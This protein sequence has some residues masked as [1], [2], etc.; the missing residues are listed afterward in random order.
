MKSPAHCDET[1][2]AV[3]RIAMWSGPR[4]ISTAMMRSFENRADCTVVD[5]PLYAHY[6]RETRHNHPGRDE[7]IAHHECELG[8]LIRLLTVDP[9]PDPASTVFYQKHMAHHLLPGMARE[10]ISSLRNCF[11]IREPRAMFASLAKVI[12]NPTIE[13]T[14]LPQQLELFKAEHDRTGDIPIVIDSRD[15]LEQPERMLRTLCHAIGIRFSKMMLTWPP[16]PRPT[17]GIWARHWYASVWQSTGFEPY[18]QREVSLPPEL[19]A[20]AQRCEEIYAQLHRQ[21]LT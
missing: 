4:N 21:R 18:Q 7:I 9:P 1:P 13:Q 8:R 5:E 16:G 17:D 3:V 10:W 2:A 6:L 15:V 12:D 11:L 14:G 20:S 19:E